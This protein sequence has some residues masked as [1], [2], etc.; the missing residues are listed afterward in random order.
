MILREIHCDR[1]KAS[2]KETMENQGWPGWG[3]ISG[4]MFEES[5][6]DTAYLC[7]KCMGLIKKFLNEGGD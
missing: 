7:P 3:A 2:Q 4:L 6:R 1:C 5:G